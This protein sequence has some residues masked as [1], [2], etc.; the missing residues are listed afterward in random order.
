MAMPYHHAVAV[1][2]LAGPANYMSGTGIQPLRVLG[3]GARDLALHYAMRALPTEVCSD[4][5]AR[6]GLSI[7]R[8]DHPLAEARSRLILPH[9]R[10]EL[11]DPAALEAATALLWQNVGRSYAEFSVLRRIVREGR[12]TQ[13]D[14]ALLRSAIADP[15]PLILC[16]LHLGNWE[17]L[18]QQMGL[19]LPGRIGA[20]VAPP[21]NR[22]HSFI[23][24]HRR[25]HLPMDF[26]DVNHHVWR[27]A[28]MR[29]RQ[30][31]G[32]LWLAADEA[33]AGHVFAPFFGRPPV[34]DG[35][36]GKM[37]R[38]ASAT[39][40]RILPIYAERQPGV[41]FVVHTLPQIDVTAD[42]RDTAAILEAIVQLDA[43]LDPIVRRLAE[44]WYMA[45]EFGYD[46]KA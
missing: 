12:V 43:Q 21:A 44:Q 31:G 29:L 13:S 15:R 9:L 46:V 22:A 40:A 30:P 10:S 28:G 6:L 16:F 35:N 3:D 34:I 33:D 38:L 8:R 19:L 1:V 17:V 25:R 18:G 27:S 4:L 24:R 45:I 2:A 14:P 36:L 26:F 23:V 7:G 5:G 32:V 42:R 41:H 20:I 39:H 11:A 37:V